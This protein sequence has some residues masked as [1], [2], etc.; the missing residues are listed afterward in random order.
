MIFVDSSI[1]IESLKGSRKEFLRALLN[2]PETRLF[3]NSI[4]MTEYL[5]YFLGYQGGKS[6]RALKEARSIEDTISTHDPLGILDFFE[7]KTESY[8]PS[9][10]VI[11]L[12]KTY[13]LLPNDAII[14]AHCLEAKIP[15]LAS[16]DTD[17][18][19][20]CQHEGVTLLDSAEAFHTYFPV[21]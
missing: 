18:G 15:Y 4:V 10:D 12:M 19:E 5:Y 8:P 14:L 21:S 17:F 2:C 1:L 3:Y 9:G 16:Y 13:N 6:P 20:P 11:R 7:F